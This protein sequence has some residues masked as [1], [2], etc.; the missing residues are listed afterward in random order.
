MRLG[1]NTWAGLACVVVPG[2]IPVPMQGTPLQ[3]AGINGATG[4]RRPRALTGGED[5][6]VGYGAG[7]HDDAGDRLFRRNREGAAVRTRK[8]VAHLRDAIAAGRARGAAEFHRFGVGVG[9]GEVRD[10]LTGE[11]PAQCAV[12]E[13]EARE[14]AVAA[15]LLGA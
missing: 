4:R 12:G 3:V 5:L 7:R 15:G 10:G 6:V 9:I 13:S 8:G 14:Q 1:A 2:V 11:K